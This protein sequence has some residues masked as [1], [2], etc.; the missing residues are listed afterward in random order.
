MC[1]GLIMW[2]ENTL[3]TSVPIALGKV[4]FSKNYTSTKIP[5]KHFSFKRDLHLPNFVIILNIDWHY[6]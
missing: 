2:T 3:F 1:D 6:G 5:R 4:V